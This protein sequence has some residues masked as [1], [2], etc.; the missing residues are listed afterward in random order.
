MTEMPTEV[1]IYADVNTGKLT[2][3]MDEQSSLGVGALY[4]LRSKIPEYM[5]AKA[6][7]IAEHGTIGSIAN[8]VLLADELPDEIQDALREEYDVANEEW[9]EKRKRA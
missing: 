2:A 1:W 3:G 6:R 4:I 8:E 5:S 9:T 7:E